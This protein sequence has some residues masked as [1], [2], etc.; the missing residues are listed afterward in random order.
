MAMIMPP[1]AWAVVPSGIGTFNIITRKQN[2][3]PMASSGTSR[4][5][6]VRLTWRA[7]TTHTGTITAPITAQVCGLRYPSG[8][9]TATP[10]PLGRPRP[11]QQD[12]VAGS[13]FWRTSRKNVGDSPRPTAGLDHDPAKNV[14][15][16]PTTG[17]QAAAG[18][19]VVVV[20]G[21]G[22]GVT[23]PVLVM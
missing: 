23:G 22:L 8:T 13:P 12:G 9:C 18:A 14:R 3:A 21:T 19:L 1:T 7:E 4:C 16:G 20:G 10:K 11:A 6:T 17:P 15:P 2:D 5:L